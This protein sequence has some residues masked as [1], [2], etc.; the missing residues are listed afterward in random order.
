LA[1]KVADDVPALHR[2]HVLASAAPTA[3]LKEPWPQRVQEALPV[4]VAYEPAAHGTHVAD[5]VAPA[6]G[7]DVPRPQAEQVP[8]VVAPTAAE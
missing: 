7:E 1:P 5:E 3:V 2:E 6:V 4:E 8:A